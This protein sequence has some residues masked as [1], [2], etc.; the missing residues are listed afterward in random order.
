MRLPNKDEFP[1]W[2]KRVS[3]DFAEADIRMHA[4]SIAYFFFSSLIP[5]GIIIAVALSRTSMSKSDFVQLVTDF[6]PADLQAYALMMI[7]QSFQVSTVMVT[8]STIWLLWSA[9]RGIDALILGLNAT[10]GV[11]E[12]RSFMRRAVRSVLAVITLILLLVAAVYLIFSGGIISIMSGI[13]PNMPRQDLF[14]T[15][16]R[17]AELVAA[18]IVVFAQ[19]Y[20]HLP[21]GSRS[22]RSQLPGAV[23]ASVALLFFSVGFRLYISINTRFAL[24]YGN[25]A[26]LMLFLLWM[27]CIFYIMLVGAFLNRLL[28]ELADARDDG[29]E[30]DRYATVEQAEDEAG[31]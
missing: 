30:S 12:G 5:L 31:A 2:A 25:F 8:I 13:F 26:T 29:D 20:A 4:G 28:A 10:F 18:V 17:T 27:Y 7:D 6:I 11:K 19:C 14:G 16:L 15:M 21:D 23:A 22:F 1:L 3:H 24:L 9:S